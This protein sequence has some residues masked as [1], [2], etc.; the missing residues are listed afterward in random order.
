MERLTQTSDKGGVAFT[1]DLDV[2]CQP[3]EMKKILKI[4]EKLKEYEDLEEQDLLLRLPCKVGDTVYYISEGFIEPCTVET[5][6]ISDYTDKDGNCSYMAEIHYDREDCPYVST[7]IYF[8]DIGKTVFLMQ[9]EAEQ[10]LK[11][12]ESNYE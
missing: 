12:M 10:K 8:T 1:F 5:I 6:F 3:S 11:E 2:T 7:E 4:A 9:A